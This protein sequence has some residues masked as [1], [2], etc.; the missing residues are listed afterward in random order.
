MSEQEIPLDGSEPQTPDPEGGEQP[1]K[2]QKSQKHDLSGQAP[3]FSDKVSKDTSNKDILDL[4]LGLSQDQIIPWEPAWLPSRGYYYDGVIPDGKVEIRAMGLFAEKILSTQRYAQTGYT[5][6]YLFKNCVNFPNSFDPLDLLAGDR[7]YLLYV[8]RGIT[9][10]NIYE[11]M[12]TC[13]N[14]AC[15]QINTYRYDLNLLMDKITYPQDSSPEPFNVVLPYLSDMVGRDFNVKVRFIRGRDAQEM[16]RRQKMLRKIDDSLPSDVD[17][18]LEDNLNLLIV[19]AMGVTD[20][21]M[22]EQLVVKFH[23]RDTATIREFLRERSPGVEADIDL[24]CPDCEQ[25]MSIDLPVTESFFRPAKRRG[26]GKRMGS[27]DGAVVST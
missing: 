11:F 20:P 14:D 25:K 9:H 18:T 2:S 17:S 8:L 23:A 13:P 5:L 24:I 26:D 16:D 27:P 22:I 3:D 15:E 7:T 21:A 19:D 1:Q 10:G 6:D 12:Y 4:V